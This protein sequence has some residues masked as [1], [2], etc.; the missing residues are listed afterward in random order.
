MKFTGAKKQKNTEDSSNKLNQKIIDNAPMSI[1]TIDKKGWMTSANKYFLNF[2]RTNSYHKHNIF[3]SAFFIREDLVNNYKKLLKS[4]GIIKKDNCYEKNNRGEDKYLKIIA[5]PLRDKNKKIEGILSMAVDNTETILF[6]NKLQE[7]N[8]N[9]EIKIKQR[10]AKLDE[11]NKE[12]EKILKLRS[13][14]M[15]NISHE[16]RTSLTI[17]QGNLE[18][19]AS[20]SKISKIKEEEFAHITGE[21]K[22]MSKMLTDLTFLTNLNSSNR[23]LKYENFFLNE[24]IDL[25]CKS[26]RVMAIKN[27]VRIKHIKSENKILIRADKE[28]LKKM[29]INLVVNAIKYNKKGGWIKIWTEEKKEKIIIKISDSGVGIAKEHL[30]YIFERFYR[31]D[32]S[33]SRSSGGFGLGLAICKWIAELHGGEIDVS[34]KLNKG[35]TFTIK[36]PR[37]KRK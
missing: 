4:G 5:V 17:I 23:K 29:L 34:S 25:I 16:L 21:I 12:L 26:L 13:N 18:L 28:K 37:K 35:T 19:I 14:F 31:V 22:R 7:L 15:E 3:K 20:D 24:V 27:N 9:L 6:K 10:T 30:P 2:S 11:V 1:I 33:R 36:L 32:K 8:N